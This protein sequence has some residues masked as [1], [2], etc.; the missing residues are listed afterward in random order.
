MQNLGFDY[1]YDKRLMDR[2]KYSDANDIRGHL[3][4]ENLYQEKLVRFIENHDEERSIKALGEDKAKMAAIII[5]TILGMRFYYDGEFEGKTVKLPVQLRREPVEEEN[6]EIKEFYLKLLNIVNTDI[7]RKG[8]W[9]LLNVERGE[10]SLSYNNILAWSREYEGKKVLI[11]INFS[12]YD[13][14]AHIRVNFGNSE[15][16]KFTDLLNNKEY[17]YKKSD[18]DTNGLFVK[19][20]KYSAHIFS[21]EYYV[22]I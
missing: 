15:K 18:L 13:S 21:C 19:L 5:S 9:S 12:E 3:R 4:A 7:F 14:S 17:E 6:K 8:S 1:T 22:T 16:I 11:I 20:K 10:D 2:I